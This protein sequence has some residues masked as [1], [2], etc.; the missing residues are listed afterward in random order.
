MHQHPDVLRTASASAPL[1]MG[2]ESLAPDAALLL[3]IE[4]CIR[5]IHYRDQ[6]TLQR[7]LDERERQ[8]CAIQKLL[9]ENPGVFKRLKKLPEA[10]RVEARMLAELET[11]RSE[12]KAQV[13]NLQAHRRLVNAY[14][15]IA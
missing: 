4:A 2:A 11:W 1:Q 13:E 15:E 5:A 9:L 8:M 7:L 6:Q 14:D 3:T 12:L 10:A